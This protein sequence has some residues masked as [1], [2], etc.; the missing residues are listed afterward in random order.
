MVTPMLVR[1]RVLPSDV[2]RV[3]DQ[4]SKGKM[5]IELSSHLFIMEME[6]E[7]EMESTSDSDSDAEVEE[8]KVEATVI[9]PVGGRREEKIEEFSLLSKE[10]VDVDPVGLVLHEILSEKDLRSL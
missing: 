5:A 1:S 10:P 9:D 7:M 6:M 8:K 2:I 4:S 3:E